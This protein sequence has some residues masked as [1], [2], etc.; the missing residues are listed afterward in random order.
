MNMKIRGAS[1]YGSRS[2]HVGHS[3]YFTITSSM[4]FNVHPA[5][6]CA[7]LYL[8]MVMFPFVQIGNSGSVALSRYYRCS[9]Y[10][11]RNLGCDHNSGRITTVENY[12][13]ERKKCPI[14][15]WFNTTVEI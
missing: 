10:M 15:E 8:S 9:S 14:A 6:L 4:D 11:H 7:G 2:T 1:N 12:V 13:A 3:S 5:I